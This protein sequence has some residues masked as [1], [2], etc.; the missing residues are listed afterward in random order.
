MCMYLSLSLS[1]SL[2]VYI[3]IYIYIHTFTIFARAR[4]RVFAS[5]LCALVSA[6]GSVCVSGIA[7]PPSLSA[8]VFLLNLFI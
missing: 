7:S 1:F 8:H 6:Y 2:C 4:P 3:Y 5:S